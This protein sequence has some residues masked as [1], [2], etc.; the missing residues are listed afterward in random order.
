M[1][2]QEKLGE[3]SGKRFVLTWAWHP[4][5][6]PTAVPASAALAAAQLGMEIVI[7][8][9]PGY[10]LDPEDTALIRRV[11]QQSGGE[12]VHII[13]DPDDAT[14]GA[15]AV[16]VK[17]WGSVKLYGNPQEEAAQRA[18]LRDW[19]LTPARLKSTRGG[20]GI[21]MHCLPV[22]R[23]VEIDDAVLDGPNSVVVD[24]AENRLHA[25]RALLLELIGQRERE[26]AGTAARSLLTAHAIRRHSDDRHLKGIAGLK[27][28][29]RYVR[30]YRDQVFVVKLGGDVRGRAGGARQRDRR[31]SRCCPRSA[32]ASWW[33]TAAGP[34]PPP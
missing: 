14:V 34:R 13:D 20:R 23:N 6:L 24:Q 4:K 27:G 29:L 9:P 15:D 32:S 25:Q 1:T 30:A 10:E 33:C 28:A 8:R 19:R 17:S 11:A 12:F 26:R 2:L 16:Y 7:A 3:T 31:S 22:R 5:A 21:V 18:A